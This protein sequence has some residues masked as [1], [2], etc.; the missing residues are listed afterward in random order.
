[1]QSCNQCKDYFRWSQVPLPS[2]ATRKSDEPPSRRVSVRYPVSLVGGS[3]TTVGDFAA[4]SEARQPAEPSRKA[5]PW[6]RRGGPAVLAVALVLYVVVYARWPSLVTQVDLQVYRFGATRVWKGLDLYSIG[7]TGNPKE[8][9]FIYP[10]FAALCFLPLVPITESAVQVLWLVLT[11]FL[12]AYAIQR[13][14]KSMR[15]TAATALWGLTALLVGLVAWLEPFRLSLQLGQ[16]NIAILAIVVADLLGPRQRRWAGIGIGLAAGIK[17]TP[18]LFIIFLA[19]IGR[20]RAAVVA[21]A[22]FAVTILVGFALLPTD[23][24]FYWLRRGFDDAGRIS[25]NPFAS[26]A[27]TSASGLLMRLHVPAALAAATAVVLA[28]IAVI[29]GAIAYRRGR[30]VLGIAVLGMAS[31]AASPF[32][33]SHHWVWFAPLMV[34]LGYRAYVE[35]SKYSAWTLWLLC[36]L[37]GGWFTSL[38]DHPE[39]GVLSLRPGGVWND[40]VPGTYV[41]VFLAAMICTA[42]WLWRSTDV[43]AATPESE[44]PR[45]GDPATEVP[46]GAR[47]SGAE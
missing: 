30:A 12:I 25:Q 41:L 9:L 29:L 1:M 44:R 36:A 40:I 20:L 24:A 19:A 42:V 35:R 11:C 5:S 8:L 37:L 16:I 34:H 4:P 21:S 45:R 28:G 39:T 13:M 15:L 46:A 31:A 3:G 26:T 47:S 43:A 27:N 22:T 7:L 18:A 6:V 33:W 2:A 32:S 14:L 23:S 38:G 17:L 10:P